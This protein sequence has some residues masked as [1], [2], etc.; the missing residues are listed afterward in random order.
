M[1]I[2]V[3]IVA[4][5]RGRRLGGTVPKQLLSLGGRTLLQRSV[6]AFDRY[7]DTSALVVVLPSELVDEGP[8]LVGVTQRPCRFV[9][10]GQ[11]RQD[12]VRQ[13][14]L[15]LPRECMTVLIHDAARPFISP[16]V[17]ARVVEAAERTGA[18]VPATTA[19][20]TVKRV[21]PGAS[22]V[23]S[24]IP[25]DEIRLAQTPQGFRRDVLERLMRQPVSAE[26]TD[27]AM[28]AE[29]AGQAVEIVAGDEA[30]VKI[31]TS[32]DLE[33]A[34]ARYAG[35]PRVGT[36][37]DLHQLVEGRPL[38]LAGVPVP[39]ARGPLGH[40]DGDVVCHALA[41]AM[42]GASGV[43]D[44]GQHFP[45]TDPV[46]KDI[47]GLE[48]LRRSAAIIATAGWEVAN[49]DV[50]VIL[51]R[52]KLMPHLTEIREA[53]AATLDVQIDQVSVKPKTN[54]QV[55]AVGRGDA[56]AA[57]AVVVLVRSQAS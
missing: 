38:V 24:T 16:A 36:G 5:G 11:R 4:A 33:A 2:G 10:G 37:Y 25:R 55:D 14:F 53:L 23:S 15:E 54:E 18:A 57:H 28:L 6:D 47:A 8:A 39:F 7:P 21:S 52:P 12:S 20:D 19:R 9:T 43:G 48:L 1:S 22:T 51:E 45:N 30:N 56:I 3:I 17:I 29:K 27:E 40:S 50:T 26:A 41:D 32:E 44:I 42:F 13:G 35:I 31:T 34:R 49:A 46:F